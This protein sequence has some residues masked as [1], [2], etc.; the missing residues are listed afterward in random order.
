MNSSG[1][2]SGIADKDLLNVVLSEQKMEAGM[3]L[4][5]IQESSDQCIRTD[6]NNILNKTFSQQKRVFDVMSSKGWYPTEQASQ[7]EISATMQQVSQ[8]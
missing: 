2:M 4:N 3:L 7:Q 8:G 6:A 5:L 1:T